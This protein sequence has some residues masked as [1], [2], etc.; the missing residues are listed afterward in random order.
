MKKL[1]LISFIVL[2]LGS[3]AYAQKGMGECWSNGTQVTSSAQAED[4][5]K[6]F[7]ASKNG[8]SVT[9]S[10][11]IQFHRGTGY[12]VAVK[13]AAG[14]T[15]YYIV[16][17][18][19]F[20]RGPISAE[21][22]DNFCNTGCGYGY[23]MGHGKGHGMNNGQIT[24]TTIAQAEEVVKQAIANLKGYTIISTEEIQVHRGTAYKVNVKDS[25]GNRLYYFV[26]PFGF[27]KGPLADT[28][29]NN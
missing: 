6:D 22:V 7:I 21:A 3:F 11:A 8:Y 23:G 25:A 28:V 29:Q 14:S 19:G 27:A 16:T 13:N 15:E 2:A 18:F 10:E 20:T 17:P 24:V 4:I 26:N 9:G 5:V 1:F 12:K